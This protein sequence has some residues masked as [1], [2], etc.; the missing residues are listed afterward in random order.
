MRGKHHSMALALGATLAFIHLAWL[1]LVATKLAAPLM[2][3]ILGLHH[4][5]LEYTM[6]D[7][8]LG[9]AV[10]LLVITFAI[11]YGIGWI[12]SLCHHCKK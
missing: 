12:F 2:D 4:M 7:F 11:G 3:F 5:E 9:K 10:L 8:D 1:I 6:L